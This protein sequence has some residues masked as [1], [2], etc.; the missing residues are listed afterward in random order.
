MAAPLYLTKGE[1][2]S[3]L[4]TRLG[5][6]GIGAA[7]GMFV[8]M[9]DDLLE[10]A[11]EQLFQAFTDEHGVRE[12]DLVT[13]AG[14]RWYDIPDTCDI[15]QIEGMWAQKDGVEWVPMF[16]GVNAGHD[17][18]YEDTYDYPQRFDL[19]YNPATSKVQIE[20]WPKADAAYAMRLKGPMVLRP[21][22]QDGHRASFDS[23]LILLYAI[24]YG[25]A[26]L[27]KADAKVAMDAW[28][29][30]FKLIK[31]NQHG[32]RVYVRR[33]PNKP[34]REVLSRPKVV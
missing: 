12:W 2:R 27:G 19:E 32:T 18:H 25:K 22:V 17:S 29:F 8:P 1:L 20:I 33:N 30:R 21:F 11:Q 28:N 23:R 6:G 4:L 16:R 3:K 34:E 7:A 31:A 14:Q 15:D 13:S 5:Y 26:H 9:A 10:E 24:A